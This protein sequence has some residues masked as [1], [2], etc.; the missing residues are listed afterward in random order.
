MVSA[1]EDLIHQV[2]YNLVE[3]AVKFVN[4][5]GYLE[6]NYQVQGEMTYISVKNS[7][8]GIPKEEI[9]KVFQRFYKSDR[10]RS[11]DKSGVGLGLNIVKTIVNLHHGEVIVRST[12]G[13]FCE[14]IFTLPSAPAP[15]KG[16]D[17]SPAQKI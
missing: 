14:F 9:S 13:Q 8:E 6:F 2:V 11:L 4:P 5:G 10:S 12:E 7:G 3:N 17:Q 16:G 15:A 1:D